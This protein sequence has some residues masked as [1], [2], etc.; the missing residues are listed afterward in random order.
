[1]LS[2]TNA[3]KP[4]PESTL[5]GNSFGILHEGVE[6]AITQIDQELLA[7]PS[8]NFDSCPMRFCSQGGVF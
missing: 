3:K 5:G 2:G 4:F 6:R 7:E 1:M 8:M